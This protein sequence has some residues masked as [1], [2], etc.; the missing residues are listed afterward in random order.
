M[1]YSPFYVGA[2]PDQEG[3]SSE[4]KVR[5]SNMAG[6]LKFGKL[7]MVHH[8]HERFSASLRAWQ[9]AV[10]TRKDDMYQMSYKAKV[11]DSILCEPGTDLR[12]LGIGSGSGEA[13]SVI[14]KKLLQRHSSVYNHRVVEPSGELLTRYKVRIV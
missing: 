9:A 5:L 1:V 12:V 8:S 7:A 10:E 4:S 2:G 11:P 3:Q 14:L 6:L 13:D